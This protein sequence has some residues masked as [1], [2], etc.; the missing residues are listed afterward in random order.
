MTVK[1]SS[2]TREQLLVAFNL[3]CQLPFGKFHSRNPD[4][5]RLAALIDRTPSALAMKLVNIASLDP[6]ITDTGRVGLKG[7][8]KLDRAMWDEMQNDWNSF[9]IQS[10]TMVDNLVEASQPLFESAITTELGI[11]EDELDYSAETKVAQSKF[12]SPLRIKCI[13]W[14]VLHYW[15]IASKFIGR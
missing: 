3:Y 4:I 6:L 12:L 1:S 14:T 11:V 2:W 9:A 8:S 7:S 15:L 13:F 5:I 10:Q